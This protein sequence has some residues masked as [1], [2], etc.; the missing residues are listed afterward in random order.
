M[1]NKNIKIIGTGI[2]LT[3]IA[4][5]AVNL[6][7][8]NSASIIRPMITIAP[9]QNNGHFFNNLVE[10]D[11]GEIC[12]IAAIAPSNDYLLRLSSLMDSDGKLLFSCSEKLTLLYKNVDIGYIEELANLKNPSGKNF[13]KGQEVIAYQQA[14]GTVEYASEFVS[15]LDHNGN[16]IFRG[17]QMAQLYAL[18]VKL[19]EATAF[20]DTPKP[21]ALVIY[22]TTD[23]YGVFANADV[24]S[25]YDQLKQAYDLRIE[26]A[27]QEQEVYT[28]LEESVNFELL[29]LFG[30]GIK[31]SLSLGENDLRELPVEKNE[32]YTLDVSDNELEKYLQYLHPSATIF[33]YSCS[34]GSGLEKENNLANKMASWAKGRTIIASQEVLQTNRVNVDSIY[35]LEVRLLDETGNKDITYVVS[36]GL[37]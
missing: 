5:G 22:P 35:P 8:K 12:S 13:F 31:D 20:N 21:N 26:V 34:T 1:D 2:L 9:H 3:A 18:G 15:A 36:S 29:V 10:V 37:K 19:D 11:I 28:A 23:Q 6:K 7:Q 4:A 27:E 33:L 17:N 16:F 24:I 14:G 32:T 30:H 25:F